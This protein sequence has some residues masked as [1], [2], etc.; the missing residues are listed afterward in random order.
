MINCAILCKMFDKHGYHANVQKYFVTKYMSVV[1]R[2]NFARVL[3]MEWSIQ[4]GTGAL[5]IMNE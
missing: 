1:P 2:F 3:V 4:R 5:Y